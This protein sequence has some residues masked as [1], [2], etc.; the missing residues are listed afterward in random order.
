ME[1][2]TETPAIHALLEILE[3]EGVDAIFGIPGGPISPLYEALFD[4]GKMTHILAKH[5]QGAA[6]MADGYAR[7]KGTLGLCCT[8]TGPGATNAI[9]GIACSYTDCIPVM[10]L[11]AQVAMRAFGKGA[12]QESTQF[13]VDLVQL[14]KPVTKL[15]TMLVSHEH[16]PDMV[17]RALRTA[18]TGKRG[19][20]HLN[21]PADIAKRPIPYVPIPQ[22]QI[23]MLSRSVDTA[24]LREAAWLLAFAENPCI[25][26]GAGV[27]L[28]GAHQELFDLATQLNIP[29]ASTPNAK[30][31]FPEDHPLSLGVFGFAGHPRADAYLLGDRVD[32]LVAVGTSFN[33]L[34]SHAWDRRLQPH[35]ALI[36]IDIDPEQIGKNYA[37]DVGVVGD[38]KAA[39]HMLLDLVREQT[40]PPTNRPSDPLA[41]VR[42]EVQ[43]HH[44]AAQL[45][46]DTLPM[47]PQRVIAEMQKVL[48]Q[49]TLF[50]VDAG[51]CFSW[52]VHYYEIRQPGTFFQGMGHAAMGHGLVASIGGKVAAPDKTVVA[53]GGDAAFAM[54]GVEIH[55]AV[56]HDLP[57]IWIV[58]N[59]RGHGMVYH[60]DQLLLKRKLPS[61]SFRSE[62]DV[63]T[64]A[65]SLG[66][67][68]VR[69]ET[70]EELNKALKRALVEKKPFVIDTVIDPEE[71]PEA[72]RGR[73][74]TLR[75]FV[76]GTLGAVPRSLRL[77][78]QKG[79]PSPR[80]GG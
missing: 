65:R 66:A 50:F 73:V 49:D 20:V 57:V 32:V 36:H 64:I 14:F 4:R 47:K 72:L 43:R 63:A 41:H 18:L 16:L 42:T 10:L 37:T 25:L 77:P 70:P 33:E 5:E 17:R 21:I 12:L 80:K 48:P 7:V 1:T 8:T 26:A 22:H 68:G 30:G 39:L 75:E 76:S 24:S 53:I 19:P 69:V 11:T 55:T 45:T 60:G 34:A 71:M 44:H 62:L 27:L 31:V 67:V 46:S 78:Q 58:L 2:S 38:A 3:A 59:N 23:R 56:E 40:F 35:E 51:N 52:M 61:S 6:F 15:S 28:S 29:V 13:G 54:C 74:H 79:P 9:T